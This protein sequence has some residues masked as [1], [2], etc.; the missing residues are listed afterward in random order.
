MQ[1]LLRRKDEPQFQAKYSA[2]AESFF[3]ARLMNEKYLMESGE[4]RAEEQMNISDL[5]DPIPESFDAREKWPD[6]SSISFI[7]DQSACGKLHLAFFFLETI[8]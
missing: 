3:R 7:R 6:C 1:C 2:G 4:N 5:D 8:Y